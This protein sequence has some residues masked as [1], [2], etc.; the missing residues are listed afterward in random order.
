VELNVPITERLGYLV[1]RGHMNSGFDPNPWFIQLG[2]TIP[3]SSLVSS[4]TSG[5]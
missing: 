1:A 4:F 5:S 3:L 2:Y